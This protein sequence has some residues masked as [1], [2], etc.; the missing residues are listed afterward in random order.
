MREPFYRLTDQAWAYERGSCVVFAQ[1]R[2]RENDSMLPLSS[3]SSV[4]Y[5]A[6][7]LDESDASVKTPIEGHENVLLEKSAVFFEQPRLDGHWTFDETGYNFMHEPIAS[8][9]RP[10]FPIAGRNYRME[11]RISLTEHPNDIIL[12]YR[13][14]VV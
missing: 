14:H 11:Y 13:V 7:L 12:R 3:V 9:S 10:L 2:D 8:E 4:R 6:F 5:S 1:I